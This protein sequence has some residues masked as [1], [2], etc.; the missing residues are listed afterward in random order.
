MLR[1]LFSIL[2]S[3]FAARRHGAARAMLQKSDSSALSPEY[4]IAGIF[5]L[6]APGGIAH[7]RGGRCERWAVPQRS[8]SLGLAAGRDPNQARGGQDAPTAAERFSAKQSVAP[9]RGDAIRTTASTSDVP[10]MG[11]VAGGERSRGGFLRRAFL[12]GSPPHRGCGHIFVL[13]PRVSEAW[14]LDLRGG[15]SSGVLPSSR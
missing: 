1:Q 5:G 13:K 11:G 2:C 10:R 14:G 9:E 15:L 4:F 6:A 7:F 12:G 8:G 3:L